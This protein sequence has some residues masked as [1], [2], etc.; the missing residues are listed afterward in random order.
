M[1]TSTLT[2][3]ET[4]AVTAV[5]VQQDLHATDNQGHQPFREVQS[6]NNASVSTQLQSHM[7]SQTN[8][9]PSPH[10]RAH[11]QTQH[12]TFPPRDHPM[13][14]PS[15]LTTAFPAPVTADTPPLNVPRPQISQSIPTSCAPLPVNYGNAGVHP[16]DNYYQTVSASSHPRL[17]HPLPLARQ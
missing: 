16:Q 13:L 3:D 5:T 6:N 14:Y 12:P 8:I 11:L 9:P 1:T 10:Q 15:Q 7:Q 2:P 4:S 17:I